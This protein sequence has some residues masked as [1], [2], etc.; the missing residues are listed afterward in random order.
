MR[1]AIG[2]GLVVL[3]AFAAPASAQPDLTALA[4][5]VRAAERGFAKTMADRDHTAFGTF[6][7]EDA[8]F[9]GR[10]AVLRGR[11]AVSAGW[12]RFFE[13]AAAPFSWEPDQVE[14]L[15]NG[16]LALSTGPVHDPQGTRIGTFISTWRRE[17]DGRW[18]VVFDKGCGGS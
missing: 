15:A 1:I 2:L 7:A 3:T 9:I 13:P 17:A 6:V 8:V 4:A 5:E 16:T 11:A 14:V 18:R 12:K 10:E